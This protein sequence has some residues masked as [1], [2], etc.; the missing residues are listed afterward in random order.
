MKPTQ[1]R[2]RIAK[3]ALEHSERSRAQVHDALFPELAK[4]DA[5]A[6]E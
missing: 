2:E 4:P 3:E 1:V 6:A 5:K